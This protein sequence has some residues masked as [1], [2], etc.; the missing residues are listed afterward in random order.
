MYFMCVCVCVYIYICVC[1]CVCVYTFFFF[2]KWLGIHMYVCMHVCCVIEQ[3]CL[4][5]YTLLAK[6][7]VLLSILYLVIKQSW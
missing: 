3:R 7:E 4:L 2:F 6:R 1:V 5:Q